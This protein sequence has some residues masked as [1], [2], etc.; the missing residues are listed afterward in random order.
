[1]K[2]GTLA[3]VAQVKEWVGVKPDNT[4]DDAMLQR[5]VDS[6]S[7]FVYSY[8]SLDTFAKSQYDEMYDAHGGQF[9]VLRQVPALEM[10]AMAINGTPVNPATGDGKTTAFTNGYKLF[11]QNLT[12]FGFMFPHCRSTVFVSYTAGYAKTDEK[13][14]LDDNSQTAVNEVWL[15]DIGAKLL[16]GTVLTLVDADP[17]PTQYSVS[18]GV[19]TFGDAV[20]EGTVLISYSFVPADINQAVVELVGER[21]KYK[22]R[23]GHASKSLGGQETVSF[24]P[25]NVPAIIKDMLNKYIRVV[26]V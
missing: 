5:L 13:H 24:Q 10:L 16:D 9:M 4:A 20:A 25:N 17:G 26:P 14:V 21:Y 8:L 2:A 22:D 12:L 15:E 19:Y 1:M 11:K 6:A 18:E 3:T 7:A 23:I